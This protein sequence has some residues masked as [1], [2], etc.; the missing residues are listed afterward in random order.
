ASA[1]SSSR[2]AT[3][4]T[5][6][7]LA[8]RPE[9]AGDGRR[10]V[11]AVR[12]R[13]GRA[14]ILQTELQA[15]LART[16]RLHESASRSW[17]QAQEKAPAPGSGAR[18]ARFRQRGKMVFSGKKIRWSGDLLDVRDYKKRR[19]DVRTGLRSPSRQLSSRSG[20]ISFF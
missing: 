7:A 1:C 20:R 5:A 14:Q 3:T 10:G 17:T 8:S 6:S 9:A 19:S 12:R 11:A 4:T 2:R 15:G 16:H 13:A 18:A